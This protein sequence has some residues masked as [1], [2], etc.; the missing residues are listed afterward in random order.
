MQPLIEDRRSAGKALARRLSDYAHRRDVMVLALPR[1]GVPVAYEIAQA[2]SLPLDVMLVRKLGLP[3]HPEC[4]MG[5]I[6]VGNVRV[7]DQA[8]I[9]SNRISQQQVDEV[10]NKERAELV[11][12]EQCYRN[13]RPWPDLA[14]QSV[15]LVDDGIATGA[16][17]Y[18]AIKALKRQQPKEVIVAVPVAP[19]DSVERLHRQVDKVICLHTPSPFYAVGRWY[20]RFPPVSDEEVSAL[21]S[22]SYCGEPHP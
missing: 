8:C 5:A 7:L 4:A 12:R 20:Q 22:M 1:G 3:F 10:T 15:V 11:R 6:A 9:D 16:T 13:H 14:G 18:A 17:M 19:E 21:L 2:L